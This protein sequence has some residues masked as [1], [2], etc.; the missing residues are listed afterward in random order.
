MIEKEIRGVAEMKS[1]LLSKPFSPRLNTD[2][3]I[4]GGSTYNSSPDIASQNSPLQCCH[5]V[6]FSSLLGGV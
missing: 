4:G 2:F 1:P 5:S 6:F 3:V